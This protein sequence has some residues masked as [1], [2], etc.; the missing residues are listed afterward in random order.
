MIDLRKCGAELA[1]RIQ[2]G[3][4]SAEVDLY[5]WMNVR[6]RYHIWHA[7]RDEDCIQDVL[8][9]S[10]LDVLVK[11]RAGK[12]E[13]PAKLFG[14]IK[15]V[16]SRKIYVEIERIISSRVDLE[17][18]LLDESCAKKQAEIIGRY[19]RAF[20][21]KLDAIRS[22]ITDH[23][24]IANPHKALYSK[25]LSQLIRTAIEGLSN[26]NYREMARRVFLDEQTNDE[27]QQAMELN[28]TAFRLL[29]SRSKQRIADTCQEV[30]G[31]TRTAAA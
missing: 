12:V 19:G 26:E 31:Q 25:Q 22:A 7:L 21:G 15:T 2:A 23:S 16:V 10:Y 20:G 14:F 24:D 4:S 6:C 3:D 11:I 8:H 5:E 13:E 1:A 28:D 27:I 9:N 18:Y 29:K 17:A 30:L